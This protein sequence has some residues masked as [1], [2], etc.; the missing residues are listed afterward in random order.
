[1]QSEASSGK[2]VDLKAFAAK[3]APVIQHHL[4]AISKIGQN[5]EIFSSATIVLVHIAIIGYGSN[6]SFSFL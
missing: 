1:M 2:D 6:L 5:A 4:D 3:T